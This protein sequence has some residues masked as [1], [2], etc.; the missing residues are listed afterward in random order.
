MMEAM[1]AEWLG[2]QLAVQRL[3]TGAVCL[4]HVVGELGH[5]SAGVPSLRN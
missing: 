5:Q 3:E 1:S 4:F 2:D